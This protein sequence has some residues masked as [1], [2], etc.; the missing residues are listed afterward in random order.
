M[1]LVQPH[2]LLA[3]VTK[4]RLYRFVQEFWPVVIK[5]DPIWNWHVEYLCNELQKIGER[6]AK[7][8]PREYDLLIN[9]PPGTTKSTICSVMFPAWMWTIMPSCRI[10]SASYG[11]DLST[12][13]S[14]KSRNV[15]ESELYRKCFGIQLTDD[16]DKKEHYEN[17]DGGERRA[18]G[19][20]GGATGFHYHIILV[21]DA[22]NPK[23]GLSK[24]ILKQADSFMTD[25][26]PT[27]KVDK[28]VTPTIMV[29]QRIHIQ[30]PSAMMLE[31]D[32][33]R[34]KLRHICLPAS[35][36][37]KVVPLKL[38]RHYKDGLL[39]PDRLSQDV[40]D[41]MEAS[42]GQYAYNAQFGQNPI[43]AGQGM[44][45]DERLEID[46]PRKKFVSVV[47]F[48][49]KAGTKDDGA[50]TAGVKMA[51]DQ[52]GKYWILH[53]K[54]GQWDSGRREEI[55]RQTAEEDGQDVVIG[56]EQEPGSG[57]K[58]SAENTVKRLHGYTV[59]VIR[60]SGDKVLRADPFSV[61]VNIG[62]VK[63][64]AGEWN[65]AYRDE[66]QYFPDGKFKDQVDASGGCFSIL[67][68][69]KK[70]VGGWR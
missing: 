30:D 33:Q 6:V 38:K 67:S 39:D 17:T 50:H 10:L 20:G 29:Q 19:I 21:D 55:I 58:E 7:G 66:L 46:I 45:K 3:R 62:N 11:Q 49:D 61:Q 1:I 14:R 57:G 4:N 63:M 40:L 65:S 13:H 48:W 32:G 56:L 24:A 23:G 53:V 35:L 34:G 64:V 68:K 27:R 26:I 36:S 54:R 41:D 18:V 9:I 31:R 70:M 69:P 16:Q 22:I 43:P 8:L 15:I 47:R 51:L 12:D 52:E 5:E 2:E 37:D 42:M 44:F 25:T 59:R 28:K 60:P